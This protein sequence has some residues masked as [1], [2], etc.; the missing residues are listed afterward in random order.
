[1]RI[2]K[3]QSEIGIDMM[4]VEI[5]VLNNSEFLQVKETLTRIGFP[6]V[7]E[8]E[9]VLFQECHILHKR[10]RYY[11]THFKHMYL[12]D[13]R[14]KS[15]T[16]NKDDVMRTKHVANILDTWGLVELLDKDLGIGLFSGVPVKV[17]KH[18]QKDDWVLKP[19]YFN[20]IINKTINGNV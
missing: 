1:M 6:K 4:P 8:G 11:I 9:N 7:V 17:V 16:L 3:L 13:G 15:T 18:N 12:L 10:G 20:K 14:T 5:K 19:K 2:E